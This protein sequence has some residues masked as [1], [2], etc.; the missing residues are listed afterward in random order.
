MG[1][2][3]SQCGHDDVVRSAWKLY[4]APQQMIM[5]SWRFETAESKKMLYIQLETAI[6][7]RM[8]KT[9]YYFYIRPG[10]PFPGVGGVKGMRFHIV[11]RKPLQSDV[12]QLV[13]IIT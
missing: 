12:N 4:H 2:N 1:K 13:Y 5:G 9:M 6:R 3:L 8:N 11:H 7:V 10:C